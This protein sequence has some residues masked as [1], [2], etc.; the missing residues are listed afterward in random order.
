[1]TSPWVMVLLLGFFSACLALVLSAYREEDPRAILR[2][3]ARRTL[4]FAC[5]VAGI[6]A[7]AALAT[8]F[9]LRP[10]A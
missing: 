1:M 7:A 4:L 8:H 5:A 10:A 2:G 9:V 3:A 6:A